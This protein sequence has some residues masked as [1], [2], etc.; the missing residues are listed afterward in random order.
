MY[1]KGFKRVTQ[2]ML[3]QT[4]KKNPRG[5]PSHIKTWFPGV[6]SLAALSGIG[7]YLHYSG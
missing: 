3:P 1:L 6:Q 4:G 2:L 5:I 7:D